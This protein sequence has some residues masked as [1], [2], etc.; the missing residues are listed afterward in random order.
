MF[1][2]LFHFAVSAEIPYLVEHVDEHVAF[3]GFS[4][5]CSAGKFECPMESTRIKMPDGINTVRI[6]ER[7]PHGRKIYHEKK[8]RC[9]RQARRPKNIQQPAIILRSLLPSALLHLYP[10]L[11]LAH[12]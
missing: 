3:H 10:I 11:A 2:I 8:I 9:H 6:E 12:F 7:A 4:Q 5:E 1:V